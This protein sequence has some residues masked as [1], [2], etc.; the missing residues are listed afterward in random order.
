MAPARNRLIAREGIEHGWH[1]HE[2]EILLAA[3]LAP[4]FVSL[5]AEHT[6]VP[7]GP[8]ILIVVLYICVRRVVAASSCPAG[9]KFRD[10]DSNPSIRTV[11]G[12]F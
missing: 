1:K 9:A 10:R 2:R 11:S 5:F 12:G 3:F 8:V 4:Q 6:S 7:V